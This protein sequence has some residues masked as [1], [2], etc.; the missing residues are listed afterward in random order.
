MNGTEIPTSRYYE[1]KPSDG[2]RS[3][4]EFICYELIKCG[5]VLKFG[6]STREY[7]L[8]NEQA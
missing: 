4:G 6:L 7:V 3:L 5:T 8:L 2:K 1:L